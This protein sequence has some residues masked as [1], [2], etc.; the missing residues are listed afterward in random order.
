MLQNVTRWGNG[1]TNSFVGSILEDLRMPDPSFYHVMF[2][3]FDTFT[4]TDWVVTETQSGATQAIAAGDGGLIAL[5]NSAANADLNSIQFGP[6]GSV[7]RPTFLMAANKDT[8][9]ATRL[10]V[11]DASL[12]AFLVG[13]CIADTSPIASLPATGMFIS[14]AAASV[15]PN[16]YLRDTSTGTVSQNVNTTPV[17]SDVFIDLAIVYQAGLG[18]CTFYMGSNGGQ[19]SQFRLPVPLTLA[20]ALLAPTFSVANGDANARTLTIDWFLAAQSRR[21]N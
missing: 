20:G 11:D 16:G 12:A 1:F 8:V 13:L 19:A 14:K 18:I 5:V 17:V 10:K 4:V 7:V 21:A 2:D 3:D 15:Y 9:F 6:G